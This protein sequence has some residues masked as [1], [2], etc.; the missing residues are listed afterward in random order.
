ME[1]VTADPSVT[2]A[3]VRAAAD[4]IGSQVVRT[5]TAASR[6]LSDITG[7]DVYVKFE[8]LQFTASYKERGALNRLLLLPPGTAGV[9]AASAGNF[10]QGVAYHASR[11]GLPAVIVMPES[12]PFI[13]VSRTEVL[14]AEVVRVGQTFEEA[15]A[16]ASGIASE[17]GYELLSPF[18]DVAVIA[19]Q[20][21]VAL[22]LLAD[23]RDLDVIIAPVGG[24]GLLA[25]MAVAARALRPDI[26]LVGV[27]SERFPAVHNQLTGAILPVGGSTIAEGIAVAVPGATTV[28]LIRALVDRVDVVSESLIEEA[29]SLLL[30]VEKSVA[31]GAGATSLAELLARP[32]RYQG[33]RVGIVLS[34]GNIDLRQLA[35]V[36]M[37]SLVKSGRLSTFWIE[38]EDRPGHLGRMTTDVGRLGGNIVDVVHRRLDPAFHARTTEVQLTVETADRQHLERLL[39]ELVALGHRV[40]LADETRRPFTPSAGG[41]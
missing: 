33:R 17:R 4:R 26:E 31:E 14:G 7:A 19:G 8:N 16:A 10:A 41:Q 34:G 29:V 11:L 23:V 30:E 39:T 32:D 6:T 1:R 9:V 20:G 13:K 27:Q 25:G 36:I 5:A 15:S 12:T 38:V 22:E 24:G 28:A 18:D 40:S 35:S 21:T 2:I 3:D 37:R